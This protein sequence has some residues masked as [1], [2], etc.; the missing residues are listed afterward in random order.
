MKAV[1][2]TTE[3]VDVYKRQFVRKVKIRLPIAFGSKLM[4]D[5]QI[6]DKA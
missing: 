2:H 5:L 6:F 4:C 3:K 1:I